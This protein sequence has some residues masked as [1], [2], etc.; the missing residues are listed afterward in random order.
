MIFRKVLPPSTPILDDINEDIIAKDWQSL[1]ET[2]QQS[3]LS[4]R[5]FYQSDVRRN[6]IWNLILCCAENQE[7]IDMLRIQ[8]P[9]NGELF[10][11]L[12]FIYYFLEDLV[13]EEFL[14]GDLNPKYYNKKDDREFLDSVWLRK[15][16]I[17]PQSY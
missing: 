13:I 12:L 8:D 15:M 5:F 3:I 17:L 16:P 10:F 1:S 7:E 9:Y 11:F 4:S 6:D 2:E 14:D